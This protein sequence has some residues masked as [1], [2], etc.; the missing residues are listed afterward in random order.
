MER[1]G[2]R[3][4]RAVTEGLWRPVKLS[5]EGPLLSHFSFADDRVLMGE[6]SILQ[7]DIMKK[8][9]LEFCCVSRQRVNLQKSRL[10]CS[11]YVP[12]H[13]VQAL[14]NWCTMGKGAW[15]VFG[16]ANNSRSGLARALCRDA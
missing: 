16:C 11:N 8:C 2:H 9:F 13:D 12:D 14:G 10:T 6:A 7:I 5:R 3:I 1:L 15:Q 4:T